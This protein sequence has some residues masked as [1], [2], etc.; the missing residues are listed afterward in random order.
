[1]NFYGL[2][3]LGAVTVSA[4]KQKAATSGQRAVAAG[5]KLA[6]RAPRLAAAIIAAGQKAL[7]T[8]GASSAP[9]TPAV[10]KTP[11]AATESL[12]KQP[13]SAAPPQRTQ[14][15][16]QQRKAQGQQRTQAQAYFHHQAQPQKTP[17]KGGPKRGA[18]VGEDV[19]TDEA[20][21][22]QADIYAQLAVAAESVAGFVGYFQSLLDQLPPNTPLAQRGIG[23]M[24]Q[25]ENWFGVPLEAALQGD[26][27]ALAK[28]PDINGVLDFFKEQGEAPGDKRW[29]WDWASLAETYLK[30]HP[31]AVSPTDAGTASAADGSAPT[32]PSATTSNISKVVI[33]PSSIIVPVGGT[34]AFKVT[35]LDAKNKP[36]SSQSPITWAASGGATIDPSGNFSGQ[37]A[38]N[39]TI[40]AT[41]DGISGTASAIVQS[42]TTTPSPSGY[43]GGGGGGYSGSYGG[44]SDNGGQD[45]GGGYADEGN[46]ASEPAQQ[47]EGEQEMYPENA[48]EQYADEGG[49]EEADLDSQIDELG[50][51][52]EIGKGGGG[53]GGGHH[54]GGH[55][56]HHGGGGRRLDG[57]GP[58]YYGP[59]WPTSGVEIDEPFDDPTVDDLAEAVADKLAKKKAHHSVGLDCLGAISDD[60]A[61]YDHG[62]RLITL[63][64]NQ[65]V[66]L[67]SPSDFQGQASAL[68]SAYNNA[69]VGFFGS[70]W[71]SATKMKNLGIEAH[72]LL[73]DMQR[74]YP[75][76]MR[77]TLPPPTLD[78]TGPSQPPVSP[79]STAPPAPAVPTGLSIVTAPQPNTKPAPPPI[80][81][82]D[83][84]NW[85]MRP[86][87]GPVPGWGVAAG[88]VGLTGLLAKLLLGGRR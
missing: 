24:S 60:S 88:G 5:Q 29:P 9:P 23:T 87:L 7:K 84:G 43:G 22:E 21:D 78:S 3:I 2:D 74:A 17:P 38:G 64:Y 58:W 28:V 69:K 76:K 30:V 14:Q 48:D 36:V 75:N 73:V 16:G 4:R 40:T 49:Q 15:E 83:K 12:K 79:M 19:A 65:Y 39:Y 63:M 20:T 70:K 82:G 13:A 77:I 6:K 47:E 44:G 25:F 86:V 26:K 56:H 46:Y 53:H 57:G 1:M 66:N 10:A 18:R 55:H 59:W 34:Q 67:G 32:Q 11:P 37:T 33:S 45:D 61:D 35:L 62:E 68:W 81:E 52:I 8:A 31:P 41:V 71:N 27:A 50:A 42:G 54:G 80:D 85:F 72:R 51:L